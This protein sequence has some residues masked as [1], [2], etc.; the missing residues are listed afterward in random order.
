MRLLLMF[1]KSTESNSPNL[2][3]IKSLSIVV[4]FDTRTKEVFFKP[5]KSFGSNRISQEFC[6]LNCVVIKATITSKSETT[7]TRAG[8]IFLP[9]KSVNGKERRT[10]SPYFIGIFPLHH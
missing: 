1:C 7:K 9:F 5:F 6:H 8:L 4:I 3:R 10:I 2:P